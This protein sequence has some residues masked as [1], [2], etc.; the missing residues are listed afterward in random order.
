MK[1][2]TLPEKK[3][4]KLCNKLSL[5]ISRTKNEYDLIIGVLNGGAI[6]A[7]EV[8][9]TNLFQGK[10]Y[11]EILLQRPSTEQKNNEIINSIIRKSPRFVNDI[12]RNAESYYLERK[13]MNSKSLKNNKVL[14]LNKE[15]KK[16]IIG[17]KKILIIDDAIDS[18]KTLKK[19]IEDI[20]NLN[21]HSEIQTA[22]LTVTFKQPLIRPDYYL[23]NRVLLRFP[24]AL[25]FKGEKNK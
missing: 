7:R 5:E 3:F 14:E 21:S 12:L 4:V 15:Q 22:V 10:Q 20:Q 8:I 11:I 25:D 19:I 23:F 13:F 24:W 2:I 17:A 18:G 6:V 9:K 16:L 1:V